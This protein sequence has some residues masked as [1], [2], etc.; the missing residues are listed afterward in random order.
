MMKSLPTFAPVALG[1]LLGCGGADGD[2]ERP[3]THPVSGVVTH[4][5][6]PV[7]GAQVVFIPQNQSIGATPGSGGSAGFGRTNAEGRYTLSTFGEEDGAVAGSYYVTITKTEAVKPPAA[8][9]QDDPNYKEPDPNYRP[10][11]P[12][13]LI[14][15]KYSQA[16]SSKLTADVKE[17]DNT[18][19]FPLAD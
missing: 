13:H 4:G 5:G 10:P 17:G 12:K 14:P 2:Q 11:A 15:K 1:L 6:K 18:F 8:V 16:T 3:P 7:E 19:D 9:D